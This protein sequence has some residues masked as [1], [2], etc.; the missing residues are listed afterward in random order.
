MESRVLLINRQM[1][2]QP[3][4][5]PRPTVL[6]HEFL[7]AWSMTL[8]GI[9][10]FRMVILVTTTSTNPLSGEQVHIF[11]LCV[12]T[13]DQG[14]IAPKVQLRFKNACHIAVH[15]AKAFHSIEPN[16]LPPILCIPHIFAANRLPFTHLFVRPG[17]EPEM[18]RV[19]GVRLLMAIFMPKRARGACIGMA[20][21]NTLGLPPNKRHK[22]QRGV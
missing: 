21:E 2:P 8:V 12:I 4:S 18:G 5:G 6:T 16:F 19:G 1:K 7:T 13:P 10:T 11:L 15:V 20:L 14:V 9:T 3:I 17:V 22:S